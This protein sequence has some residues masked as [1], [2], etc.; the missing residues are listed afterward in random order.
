MVAGKNGFSANEALTCF[1]LELVHF[2][3]GHARDAHLLVV[4]NASAAH[5]L[6]ATVLETE[7]GEALLV[8]NS[9]ES[10]RAVLLFSGASLHA[11]SRSRRR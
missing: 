9:T 8:L 11:S 3:R 6:S 7:W 5:R 1:T 4:P 2:L 10:A